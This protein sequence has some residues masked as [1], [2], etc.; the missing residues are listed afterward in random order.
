MDLVD[1]KRAGPLAD[2]WVQCPGR[3]PFYSAFVEGY[4]FNGYYAAVKHNEK[5]DRNA[6]A[7]Y[8][9]LAYLTWAD[10]VVSDDEGFFRSAFDAIWR[11]RG[12]RL[13]SSRS[14]VELTNRLRK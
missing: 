7:D 9:Q 10:V 14:F 12:K 4:L 5:I 13:E 6:Q 3:F 2:L 11:P 1:T 8:E